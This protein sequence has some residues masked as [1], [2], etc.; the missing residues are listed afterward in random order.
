MTGAKRHDLIVNTSVVITIVAAGIVV[1]GLLPRDDAATEDA[2][3]QNPGEQVVSEPVRYPVDIPGC[4][5]VQAPPE[6]DGSLRFS[7]ATVGGV[8]AE[9]DNPAY[10]WLT[11]GK[12]TAMSEAVRAAL[13]AEADVA[14][15]PP[16]QSFVFQPV[17]DFGEDAPEGV[18]PLTSATGQVVRDGSSA[19]ASISVTPSETGVPDCV[20]GDLDVRT[21]GPDGTVVDILDTWYE[22]SGTRTYTRS[23]SA[24]HPDG[25]R[26]HV[27]LSGPNPNTLPLEPT[28]VASIAALPELALTAPVP[29]GTPAPRQD[30]SVYAASP[31]GTVDDISGDSLDAAN[32]ALT[33]AWESI[34]NAPRLSRPIGSLVPDGFS[35][36][37]C[38]D[39]DVVDTRIGLSI[40][41]IGGQVLPSPVD[42]YDPA[43]AYGP[44]PVTRT[45]PD[46]SVVQTEDSTIIDGLVSED[47]AT[48]L[49]R[50]V[51]LTR[52]NGLQITARSTADVDPGLR[53]APLALP[54]PLGFDILETLAQAPIAEWP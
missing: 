14:L 30:C 1:A 6:G 21:T 25:T 41:V 43:T 50:S 13:P 40:S 22:V 39:V 9:Y 28:D 49:A 37:A 19:Y 4:D 53:T 38:T 26:V 23:A 11:A 17:E 20:A 16:S 52:P 10:P 47:G 42:P 32:A 51:S 44:L 31:G 36:G 12:A 45:L 27:S 15:A 5:T 8:D 54:E 34:P 3:G 7:F 24:Y 48:R 29:P 35:A 46:G 18:Q 2:T 33:A